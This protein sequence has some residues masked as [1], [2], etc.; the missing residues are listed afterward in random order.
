MLNMKPPRLMLFESFG[1]KEY[2]GRDGYNSKYADEITIENVRID[3]GSIYS[4][5]TS[6]KVLLYNTLIICYP[7]ITEP[8]PTF[9]EQSK[10]TIDGVEQV[11]QKVILNK[12]PTNNAIYSIELELV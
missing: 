9:K 8:V 2:L 6:G 3:R 10:V 7:G 12:E 11:I 5:S 4:A 1:Y